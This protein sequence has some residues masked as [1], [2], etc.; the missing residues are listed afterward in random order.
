MMV[1]LEREWYR[2]N[3]LAMRPPFN[4]TE[5]SPGLL[6]SRQQAVRRF[7]GLALLGSSVWLVAV[8]ALGHAILGL[9]R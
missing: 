9:F 8:L 1:M 4:L 6:P 2:G 5:P 7:A 3:L